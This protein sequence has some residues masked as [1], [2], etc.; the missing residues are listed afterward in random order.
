V[1]WVCHTRSLAR[2]QKVPAFNLAHVSE[3]AKALPQ[4]S[5]KDSGAAGVRQ[6]LAE[7]GIRFV[8]AEHLPNTRV[9]G[10]VFWLDARSPVVAL[11]LRYDRIDYFWFTLM[12]ELAHVASSH[13]KDL[14]R[15]DDALVGHDRE[16]ASEKQTEEKHVDK[17]ASEWLVPSQ[18][19]AEFVTATSPYFS[20]ARILEFA[21]SLGIHPGI[22][23]GRLQHEGHVPWTHLRN[24]LERVRPQLAGASA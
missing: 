20:R 14:P 21:Q 23:V 12:H 8:V 9:D 10:A 7:L 11:S 13:A 3:A 15:I 1:A 17:L 19:L 22:V 6:R 5:A 18:R 16:P 24:L 4:I 2:K